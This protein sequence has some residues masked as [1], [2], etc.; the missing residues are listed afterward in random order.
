MMRTNS[1]KAAMKAALK[2]AIQKQLVTKSLTGER[3]GSDPVIEVKPDHA[4]ISKYLRG[5]LLNV[6]DGAEVEKRL[7]TKA[8]GQEVGTRGGFLVPTQV[9]SQLIPLLK[10]KSVVRRMPGVK[11]IKMRS[12]KLEFGRVDSGPEISWGGEA[13]TIAEDTSLEFGQNTLQ[14][15]KAVCLYKTSREL[16]MNANPGIDDIVRAELVEALALE[17]D[18]V[19]LAGT[20]G[21]MPLGLLYMPTVNSTDLSGNLSSDDL[22]EAEYNVRLAHAEITG[23]IVHPRVGYSI[24]RWKD[25]EGRYLLGDGSP[26]G[27]L[28]VSGNQVQK[29]LGKTLLQS[30]QIPITNL[31]STDETAM[32]G[33]D[34]SHFLIGENGDLRIETSA[35]RYF[36]SDQIALRL[37]RSVGSLCKQ[38]AAFVVVKGITSP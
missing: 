34:W 25:A 6:W 24:S 27:G 37:C 28:G 2:S 17:E 38:P 10:D 14:V 3:R 29:L 8:L 21:S 12:D 35:E 1:E 19:F 31:P 13:V 32:F 15:K 33:G 11:T 18:R 7:F 20:G 22:K 5:T 9:S 16:L 4:S 26:N 30:T 36:E 23:W